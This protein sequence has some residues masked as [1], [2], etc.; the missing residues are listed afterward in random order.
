MKGPQRQPS[1]DSSVQ[2]SED[3]R[4]LYFRKDLDTISQDSRNGELSFLLQGPAAKAAIHKGTLSEPVKRAHRVKIHEPPE[5]RRGIFSRMS[6]TDSH[7]SGVA[8]C[9]RAESFDLETFSQ[10]SCADGPAL[11]SQNPIIQEELENELPESDCAEQ[12]T[13]QTSEPQQ[14]E[15]SG[16]APPAPPAPPAPLAPL[17]PPEPDGDIA[18]ATEPDPPPQPESQADPLPQ[19]QPVPQP[20][21]KAPPLVAPSSPARVR[22]TLEAPANPRPSPP[23]RTKARSRSCPR[24]PTTSPQTPMASRRPALQWQ[25]QRAQSHGGY[26]HQASRIP[27][28][29]SLSDSSSSSSDSLELLPR[30]GGQQEGTLQREMKALFDQKMREIRCKSPLFQDGEYL[31]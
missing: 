17:A 13:V 23:V 24:K 2:S 21:A 14:P 7:H 10:P 30:G 8:P 20:E 18:T 9:M 16:E 1:I 22:R 4:A 29:L 19:P 15:V 27:N 5:T 26:S 3:G 6:S 12:Q 31:R 28:G 11:D 25:A